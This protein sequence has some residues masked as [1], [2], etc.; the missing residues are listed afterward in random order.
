[1]NIHK[2][3]I[4]AA[5]PDDDILGCGGLLSRFRGKIQFK[6]LFIAEGTS[7]RF[8]N[9]YGSDCIAEIN[10]RTK[11][12]ED[13]LSYLGVKNISVNNLKCCSLDTIGHLE[14][15]K[16]IEKEIRLFQP[17][18]VFTHSDCDSNQ[19][20]HI[21]YNSTIIATRPGSVVKNLISYEV[22]SSTE[23]GFSKTFDPNLFFDLPEVNI[24]EKVNAL[25][26]YNTE[27][28]DFPYPRSAKGVRTLANFRG[29]QSGYE[30]AEAFKVIRS[31]I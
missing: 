14:V 7:A 15:N 18:T 23:W 12:A 3:L 6:V 24:E 21:V 20:H 19:D 8:D 27:V 30:N 16:I 2:A 25:E 22:L 28:K 26:F 9:N 29:L 1:M 13:A 31:C 10:H 5:H 11:C 4:V 17:D